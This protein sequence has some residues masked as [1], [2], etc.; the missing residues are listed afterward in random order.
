SGLIGL[1]LVLALT[2]WWKRGRMTAFLA[3][4]PAPP[5]EFVKWTVVF[6]SVFLVLEVIGHLLP[7]AGNAFMEKV[8]ASTTDRTLLLIGVGIM[9]ALFEEFLLRGLLYGSLRHVMDHHVAI[10]LVAGLFT[11][12][13]MQYEWYV[14]LLIVLPMGVALGYA[15][16]NS[17]SI[18]VP[19]LLHM[20]NNCAS[21]LLP[22]VWS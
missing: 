15:R 21:I 6:V 1:A 5:R 8:L 4:R 7:E 17:G 13:H 9:P 18:W 11:L 14:L 2:W 12:L 20:V 10:A 19:V 16:A 22:Q 3:L